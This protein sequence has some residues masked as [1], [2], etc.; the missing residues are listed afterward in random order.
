MT[1]LKNHQSVVMV[2]TKTLETA[3]ELGINVSVVATEA[4]AQA[5]FEARRKNWLA[6]YDDAISSAEGSEHPS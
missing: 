3:Q 1:D 6:K 4:L 5:I 2:D